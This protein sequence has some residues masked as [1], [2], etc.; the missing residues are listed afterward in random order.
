MRCA[1]L[2]G[3]R[4]PKRSARCGR[5]SPRR[6]RWQAPPRRA[7][8]WPALGD[9]VRL[10]MIVRRRAGRRCSTAWR[11]PACAF[12]IPRASCG[13]SADDERDDSPA[14]PPSPRARTSTPR[15][16]A[17]ARCGT[18]PSCGEK[19]APGPTARRWCSCGWRTWACSRPARRQP[20]EPCASDAEPYYGAAL[21]P[22]AQA[23]AAAAHPGPGA[24]QRLGR[25][26][27]HQ[28]ARRQGPR[29]AAG[30]RPDAQ[31]NHLR[32]AR[33]HCCSTPRR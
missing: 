15:R 9:S 30:H 16:A 25:D 4:C 2:G 14:G 19:S 10:F 11:S 29:P 12:G 31:G 22:A 8:D 13:L 32:Q 23:I 21:P 24:G 20:T 18:I 6:G 5:S 7:A 17:C 1:A 26:V 28:R 27:D 33:R 3:A